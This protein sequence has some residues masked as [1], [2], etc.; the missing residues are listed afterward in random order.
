MKRHHDS[1]AKKRKRREENK[2]LIN[3]IPKLTSFFSSTAMPVCP[4]N[5]VTAAA[6]NNVS[7]PSANINLVPTSAAATIEQTDSRS[8]DGTVIDDISLHDCTD[9]L[10][11]VHD[12]DADNSNI[13]GDD[14]PSDNESS[15]NGDNDDDADNSNSGGDDLPSDNESSRNGDNDEGSL[16]SDDESSSNDDND[17][18]NSNDFG[19]EGSNE[20]SL[21]NDG[22]SSDDDDEQKVCDT[23]VLLGDDP[24]E[25]PKH[26]NDKERCSIVRKGPVQ[27]RGMVFPKNKDTGRRF[28]PSYYDVTLKNG[29][30]ICRSWLVYSKSKDCVFCFC[31]LLFGNGMSQISGDGYKDW[32]NL[33]GHLKDHQASKE[34]IKNTT[35][36]REL[37]CRLK[38]NTAIDQV[39]QDLIEI[40]T[41]RWKEVLKRLILIVN[42]LAERNLAFR[43]QSDK[44]FDAGNGNFL[45]HVQFVAKFDAVM[46]EHLRR[47]QS[48]EIKDG[49]LSNRIQNELISLLSK[50][51]LDAIVK[52]VKQARYYSVIMDCTPDLSSQEQLSVVLRVVN[53]EASKGISINEHFVGFLNVRDTT[54][55][56]LFETFLGHLNTLGLDI[57][58]CRGQSYDNGSNMQGKN[59]GVQTRV[60]EVNKKAL[61]VPCGSHTLN[62]VINDA[63]KSSLLSIKF[64]SLLQQLYNLFSSSVQRWAILRDH[65]KDLTLKALSTTRWECRVDTVKAVRYQLPQI[66]K[67]LN[68]LEEHAKEKNEFEV[69]GRAALICREMLTWPFMVSVVVWY[70]LL[71]QVNKVSKTLQSP[72]VSIE[73]LRKEV[74]GMTQY[75]QEYR[76]TG[77]S[78]AKADAREIAESLEVEMIWPEVRQRKK[79]KQFD[80]ER[81]EETVSTEEERFNRE[82]FLELINLTMTTMKDRFSLME[83]FY[84]IYGFLYSL[85]Q[86]RISERTGKLE[87]CCQRFEQTMD[88]IEARDLVREV[89]AAV[90]AFPRDISSPYEMLDYIYREDGLLLQ[91]QNLSIALRLLLTLPVTVAS[92]ERSFSKL[93]LIKTYLRTTMSQDRLSDLG[94]LSIEQ[95]IRKSLDMEMESVITQF[96]EAKAR[97]VK[98]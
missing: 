54:G 63:A 60:K 49:Y 1:G 59:V 38:T 92:G 61:C 17:Y 58:D 47:I 23:T 84:E 15:S 53:C 3:K 10:P 56:G 80:Y 55:K 48:K 35:S 79:T 89:K 73:T 85:K 57:H 18:D 76:D 64:F 67:A 98:F 12:S 46:A 6:T 62:L 26:I 71:Y 33:S 5:V 16:P 21:S 94:I 95:D 22:D 83:R 43:G 78:S 96:A 77:L 13:G 27:A 2:K 31:C 65:V 50:C 30:R 41:N 34:H 24:A 81:G 11:N 51:T 90:R 88:D 74:L 44:L 97:K 9:T 68:A 87:E 91:Y 7:D 75:L 86:M 40:E 14:L 45:K 20:E 36:W 82:F 19:E 29:D 93:K 69:S 66:V 8:H 52:K 37:T 72:K 39:N 28:N 42:D 4:H 32:K 70:D 25:W